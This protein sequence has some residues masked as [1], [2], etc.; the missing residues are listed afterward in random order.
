MPEPLINQIN[1][2]NLQHHPLN[3]KI[4]GDDPPS[5]EFIEACQHG[6]VEH[7]HITK[8]MF[9]ISGN[10]RLMAALALGMEKVP[11]LIRY[12]LEDPLDIEQALIL[13]NKHREKT[14]EM[15]AKEFREIKRIEAERA[16]VRMR[17]GEKSPVS[18][19]ARDLA[20]KEV[21]WS[22]PT[23]DDALTVVETIEEAEASGDQESADVIRE[24]LNTKSVHAAKKE[25]RK[26][27]RHVDAKPE[28][29][30]HQEKVK[31]LRTP[32]ISLIRRIG[33]MEEEF[34]LLK[35]NPGGEFITDAMLEDFKTRAESLKSV[36]KAVR[37]TCC[38]GC[39][40]EGCR[41]CGWKGYI[42]EMGS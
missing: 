18:G 28:P 38:K 36:V 35:G 27:T 13:A 33:E 17:S 12:D 14:A 4:Y 37:P 22:G 11:V 26:R 31:E 8:D 24:T 6:I 29:T 34:S 20:A 40:A 19:S 3:S 39:D 23:A 10:R 21:G 7:L 1:P 41:I 30:S 16:K 25:A 5:E 42:R 15:R 9:V 32:F 2:K